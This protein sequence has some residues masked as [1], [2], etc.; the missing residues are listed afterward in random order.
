MCFKVLD[1]SS[2]SFWKAPFQQFF[3][4]PSP[5]YFTHFSCVWKT[6]RMF[7][8]PHPHQKI[9]SKM[10]CVSSCLQ[11]CEAIWSSHLV[12]PQMWKH[13]ISDI[14]WPSLFESF[15][16]LYTLFPLCQQRPKPTMWQSIQP[17]YG[18]IPKRIDSHGRWKVWI[19]FSAHV[20]EAE[21][22]VNPTPTVSGV[23]W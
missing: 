4:H 19:D 18:G 1:R 6:D 20:S 7:L 17:C 5:N 12:C 21:Q 10:A 9:Q 14:R 2:Y 13:H 15:R 22:A 16:H 8:H 3:F 23:P 11:S